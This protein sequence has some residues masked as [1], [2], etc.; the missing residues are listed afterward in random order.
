M[1]ISYYLLF[2]GSGTSLNCGPNIA[3]M[4]QFSDWAADSTHYIDKLCMN[5]KGASDIKTLCKTYCLLFIGSGTSLNCGPDIT[6]YIQL[7]DWAADSTHYIDKLCMN[8]KGASG[9]DISF[10]SLMGTSLPAHHEVS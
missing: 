5:V 3:P 9:V 1:F 8:V 10:N 7:S 6:P 4:V 2:I